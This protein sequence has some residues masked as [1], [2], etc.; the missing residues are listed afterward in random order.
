MQKSIVSMTL[1]LLLVFALPVFSEPVS[2]QWGGKAEVLYD[3]GFANTVMRHPDGGV[4]LFNIELTE[5]DAP[6]SGRSEKGISTDSIWGKT[7]ARKILSLDEP[8]AHKAWLVVFF[9]RQGKYPLHITVNGKQAQFDN[10]DPKKNNEMYRWTEF[11]A[12]WLKKG[13]NVFELFC[14]EAENKENGWEL[15]LARA[16]EFEEGGGDPADVGKTSYKSVDGGESWKQSPFGPLGQT[17]AEYTIR[18]SLDRYHQT[19]WLES[20]VIDL[21]KGD[22]ENVIVPLR[23][24][25]NMKISIRS[26]VPPDTN[27]EYFFRKGTSPGPFSKDWEPYQTIGD[28]AA[29]DFETGGPDLNRRYVQFRAVLTTTNPL[30]S[31]IV[32]TV[33]VTADLQERVPLHENMYVIESYNPAIKYSSIEWEWEKWDRPEFQELRKRENLDEVIAG[34][35]TGFDAQVKLMDHVMKRWHPNSPLPEYPGWD[36]LSIIERTEYN[37]GGGFCIQFANVLGGLCMAYGWQARMVNCVGHEVIE[38]WNDEYGKW[39]FF[40][41]EYFNHYNYSVETGEPLDML[42]LHNHFL[43]YY[44]PGS[45]IDWMKDKINWMNLIDGKE[46]PVKRGISMDNEHVLKNHFG[47]VVISG[48]ANAAFLRLVPR[49]NWYEKPYP[50]PLT[51]GNSW[52]PW[53]GYVNWYDKRTPP[54]RQYSWHTDRPRDMW[55][56]LNLVHVDMTSGFGNDRLYLR[57]ETYTPNFKSFEVDVD[58]TGW[59]EVGERWTW[60]LQSGRNTMRVRAVN[61]LGAKGKPSTFIIDRTDA[62]FGDFLN[63]K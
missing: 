23:E 56:D 29:L 26:E 11:P 3:T 10:W 37:G 2:T 45:T 52:W 16:D 54:K 48:F 1:L 5:N 27:V 19:G 30:V 40:D 51:H 24:I 14:P 46:S 49:N 47:R 15:Y 63:K 36:A 53:D 60:L 9:T 13:R 4:S 50:R 55:P 7:R 61:K 18:L 57:F 58:D 43:D 33:R 12:E 25:Q 31:P 34:S 42:E 35:R 39:I 41:A 22:S 17:R 6:G 38:V 62:P 20:P 8:R 21:W 59:K 32:K 44:F 28:G